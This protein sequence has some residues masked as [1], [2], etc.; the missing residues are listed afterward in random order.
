MTQLSQPRRTRIVPP[1]PIDPEVIQRERD[2]KKSLSTRTHNCRHC[3]HI[4]NRDHNAARNILNLG[5]RTVGHTETTN[6]SGETGQYLGGET[7][8]SKSS[9]GKRKPKQ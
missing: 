7:P 1:T 3:G 8:P 2:V 9:R 5:L 6:A 4:Q